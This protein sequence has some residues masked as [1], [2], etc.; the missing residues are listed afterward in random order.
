MAMMRLDKF[1]SDTG[2]ASR[3][4]AR[5]LL[6]AGR[7]TVD[8]AVCRSGEV[9]LDPEHSRVTVDG[10]PVSF[11]KNHYFLLNKPLG[12]ITATE[13]RDQQT[14]LD[15]LPAELRR[16]GLFPVGRLDK[17]TSGLLLLT[18]DGDYAHR[19]I[20]PKNHVPKVYLAQVDTPLTG[21]EG[22]RFAAGITLADGTQCLP[23]RLEVLEPR[24]CR[25]TIF[26][27]KYHQVRRMLA[28]CGHHVTA[29]HRVSIGALVMEEDLPP[30]GFTELTPEEAQLVFK[31]EPSVRLP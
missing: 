17:D 10:R 27:G 7:V 25:V 12:V 3:R 2:T 23:G 15:L 24:L 29:L 11:A 28:A 31:A 5:G 30:A 13:D 4:E 21:E 26:E 19:I 1:L 9:K 14:V 6:R 18:D 8:G 16:L 20:S 22:A